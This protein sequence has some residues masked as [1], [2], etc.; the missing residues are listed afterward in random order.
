M[1]KYR[2][3]FKD[4]KKVKWLITLLFVGYFIIGI[5]CFRDYGISADEMYERQTMWVNIN[6]I[7]TL[8]GREPMDVESLSTYDDKYYGSALQMPMWIV[9]KIG[10]D[11][12][13]I[14][15]G[16]HFY[17][18]SFCV[19]GYIFFFCMCRKLL[20][21]DMFALLGTAMLALYPRFFAEQFYNIKDM[22]FMSIFVMGMWATV[23]L[24]ESKFS[25]KCVVIFC[26]LGGVAMTTRMPAVILVLVVIGYLWTVWLMRKQCG[27]VYELTW[28]RVILLTIGIC[29]LFYGAFLL[30]LPGMW[31]APIKNTLE[32]FREF[33]D[34]TDGQGLLLFMG[35]E[36]GESGA[37]W[38]YI[39]I[40]LLISVPVWYILL[41]FISG[42][43]AVFKTGKAIKGKE[44]ILSKIF[45]EN[46]YWLWSIM[47]AA[48]PWTGMVIMGSTLY[49]G[50]RHCYFL[51]P[52]LLLFA[53]FG[54][55]AAV[56]SWRK[57]P[58]AMLYGM[59][60]AGMLIQLVWIGKNHPFEMVYFNSIGRYYADGF[61][62]DYWSLSEYPA[63][64]Y[65]AVHDDSDNISINTAGT[66]FFRL[67]LRE[68]ELERVELSDNPDYFV[69][70]YRGQR[71]N[72][73]EMEGYE[74][75]YSFEVDG[76]KVATIFKK[77]A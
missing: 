76:F 59:V 26:M 25:W 49:N 35:E 40:W 36:I 47:L 74:E 17:T 5:C 77:K 11:I 34:L 42:G 69:Y 29:G 15:E 32:F 43:I 56:K 39:P 3:F 51:A 52:P 64:Q 55:R 30:F 73:Y 4:H 8:L 75:Y 62:R 54:I 37:P 21:S 44:N 13:G 2:K 12:A 23:Q 6:Y 65:I 1:R 7:S 60:A 28:K 46:K 10:N 9:E 53:L 57:I 61:D 70:M 58:K 48:I 41:F 63:W 20:E 71:G 68:D 66:K 38:Y 19:I 27:N 72:N 16:R 18:F 22:V 67:R 45:L 14:M 24:I 33:S 31:E 50:W